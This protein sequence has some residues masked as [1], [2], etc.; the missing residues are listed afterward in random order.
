[1]SKQ[2]K[3]KSKKPKGCG[4]K[5]RVH[6]WNYGPLSFSSFDFLG[7]PTHALTP[8]YGVLA[9]WTFRSASMDTWPALGGGV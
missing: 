8:E 4:L 9:F 1:M 5:W 2:N 7:S 3:K 6:C